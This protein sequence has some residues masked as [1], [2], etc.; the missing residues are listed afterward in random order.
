MWKKMSAELEEIC[1]DLHSPDKEE[2][3]RATHTRTYFP[4]ANYKHPPP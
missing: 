2:N 1:K 4:I 3:D